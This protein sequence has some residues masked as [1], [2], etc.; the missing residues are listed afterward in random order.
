MSNHNSV[1][2]LIKTRC[3]NYNSSI[4]PCSET[5]SYD[6][7]K[8]P[9]LV[10]K[11]NSLKNPFTL[12]NSVYDAALSLSHLNCHKFGYSLEITRLQKSNLRI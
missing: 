12:L 8:V 2:Y 5:R 7:N 1:I 9:L 4:V 11:N 6:G 3:C 10:V